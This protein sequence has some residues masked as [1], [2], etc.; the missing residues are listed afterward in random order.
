VEGGFAW[1]REESRKKNGVTKRKGGNK[2]LA[3]EQAT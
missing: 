1:V 2:N 3:K